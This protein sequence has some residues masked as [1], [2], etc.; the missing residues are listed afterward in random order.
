[1]RYMRPVNEIRYTDYRR[2]ARTNWSRSLSPIRASEEH[3]YVLCSA[4]EERD[5]ANTPQLTQ[6]GG[7][8]R[9]TRNRALS[10]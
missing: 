9:A 6:D 3:V 1:M 10:S 7:C 4:S 2:E 5:S 8:L